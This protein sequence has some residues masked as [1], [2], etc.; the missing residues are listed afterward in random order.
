MFVQERKSRL[1]KLSREFRGLMR[2][3]WIGED[4]DWWWNISRLLHSIVK[5]LTENKTLKQQYCF[6]TSSNIHLTIKHWSK[7]IAS[8][9]PSNIQ[10]LMKHQP[11]QLPTGKQAKTFTECENAKENSTRKQLKAKFNEIASRPRAK[12]HQRGSPYNKFSGSWRRYQSRHTSVF[13]TC[14]HGCFINMDSLICLILSSELGRE[15]KVKGQISGDVYN[16]NLW[17]C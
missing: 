4:G 17:P 12:L 1:G 11:Q 15:I 13:H 9:H 14:K 7:R 2:G 10:L 16:W 6:E 8:K 5:H 3:S